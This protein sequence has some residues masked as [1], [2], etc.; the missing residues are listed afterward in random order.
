MTFVKSEKTPVHMG[1]RPDID[2][3][4]ALAVLGVLIYH[5]FPT[6]M[7]GG[8]IGVDVFFVISGFII[9]SNLYKEL[10]SGRFSFASFYKRRIRRI[11]PA[12]ILIFAFVLVF[13][14][15]ALFAN[16]YDALSKHVLYG[17]GFAA[18]FGYFTE[19][20]YFDVDAITKPLLH[21][22]SLGI[23]EQF[24]FV[25]PIVLVIAWRLRANVYGVL[26]SLLVLSFW[27]SIHLIKQDQVAAFYLPYS[28]FWELALG[29]LLAAHSH[30]HPNQLIKLKRHR[31]GGVGVASL[32]SLAGLMCIGVGYFYAKEN[33]DF[34]GYWALLPTLGCGLVIF[35]GVE[36]WWNRRVL[37]NRV[38]VAVGLISFP[39]YL[40]HWPLLSFA[41]VVLGGIPPAW[42]RGS[43][44]VASLVL[45]WLT[46]R[47]VERPLR[48]GGGKG[49]TFALVASMLV[50]VA[51]GAA[52]FSG[53]GLPN[54]SIEVAQEE[55]NLQ[56]VGPTWK[57][58]KNDLCV[59]LYPDTFR[60]F[61]SQ[62]RE[63]APTLILM[64]NSYANH[65]YG[66]LVEDKRFS[67][68]NVLSYG[69]C[70]PGGYPIDCETQETIIKNNPSIKFAILSSLWPRLDER[71]TL[72]DMFTEAEL[73]GGAN[74]A[75]TYVKFLDEKLSFLKA[76]GVQA[77]IFSPK[78]EVMY[79]IR[80][81]FTR[82]FGAPANTCR[83]LQSEVDK[84]QAGI[85]AVIEEVH[86]LHPDVP[87]F[88]QNPL[89]CDSGECRLVKDGMPL[90]RD[91]R[92]YSEF[93]SRQI[94]AL[95]AE[96]AK[97][98]MPEILD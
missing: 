49:K 55:A 10:E 57:Y 83:V 28:R 13:G 12:L 76:Q 4:R 88:Q 71:G 90:L 6:L 63:G 25:W 75:A 73:P 77:V 53:N 70:Q 80:T 18:N 42:I 11:F 22:W 37:A 91:F 94:I 51:F 44:V 50:I 2:G 86:R 1:Y 40:W 46:F 32:A 58:T 24:Y 33:L 3:L 93:G 26:I 56:M 34:P 60:Y 31:I 43:I 84:Q 54:R 98:N 29:A 66:G 21:L 96:W 69:S 14:W 15:Y 47:F 45:A 35:A 48:Y 74:F 5:A 9:S 61:C 78:P 27:S 68:Q 36:S 19:S 79:D 59:S 38:F 23:E 62:E 52:V 64:G 67:R 92:H 8:F 95:F 41:H 30:F 16:E 20:G 72:V 89:F 7:T 39:L 85:D 81:C 17:A 87:V 82:P 97:T 65:L